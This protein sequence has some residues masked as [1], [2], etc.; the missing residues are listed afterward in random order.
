MENEKRKFS[1]M[2]RIVVL[3]LICILLFTCFAFADNEYQYNDVHIYV[4]DVAMGWGHLYSSSLYSAGSNVY[5]VPYINNGYIYLRMINGVGVNTGV[6]YGN[7]S[8]GSVVATCNGNELSQSIQGGAYVISYTLD[9]N[10]TDINLYIDSTGIDLTMPSITVNGNTISWDQQ[11]NADGYSIRY[12]SDG[13][14]F[15][16]IVSLYNSNAYV[17]DRTGYYTVRAIGSGFY[18]SSDWANPVYVDVS[19]GG[20]PTTISGLIDWFKSALANI[21]ESLDGIAETWGN[22][23]GTVNLLMG[24]IF[25]LF[26]TS[27]SLIGISSFAIACVLGILKHIL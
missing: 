15:N 2:H 8:F 12:S 16:T 14:Q 26:P 3:A 5:F 13:H 10:F 7:S 27:I 17:C 24:H 1:H 20:N 4:N 25:E 22:F 21:T 6:A 23:T 19:A 9:T 11:A 18:N